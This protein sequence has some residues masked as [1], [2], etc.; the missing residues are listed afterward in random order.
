LLYLLVAGR[1]KLFNDA[2]T[3]WHI[4]VGRATLHSGFITEDN[5]SFTRSGEPW[6]ANQWLAECALAIADALG[7][8]DGV[9]VLTVTVLTA[10][11]LALAHRWLTQGFDPLLTLAVVAFLLSASAYT[12]NARPHIVSIGLLGWTFAKLRDV[13]D[14]RTQISQ[15]LWLIPVFILWSN[16]HGGVLG[17]L[18]TIILAATGW[19]LLWLLGKASPITSAHDTRITWL[20]IVA[21][22]FALFVT[23]YGIGSLRAWLTIMSMS[24]PDL[25]IEHAPLLPR[26]PQGMLVILLALV[27]VAIF[28]ATPRAWL[29]P[30]FWLPLVWFLLTCQRIRHAPL[31]A[32]VAGI[33]MADLLPQSRIA[34]WL[35]RRHWL[36]PE[37]L[38]AGRRSALALLLIM[39]VPL[40]GVAI[41][42]KHAGPLPLVRASWV[43]PPARVWPAGLIEPLNSFAEQQPEGTPVFNEPILGGFLIDRFT[44][45]RVFIDGRCEL[46]GEPF[47]H[48]FVHAWSDPSLI[49]KWQ[50][51]FG[52]RAALIEA[53]SPLRRYFDHNP[54][55]QLV[56][57]AH[58]ARFYRMTD[59][60]P[61]IPTTPP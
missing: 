22:G 15:L 56:G 37:P 55:W 28:A 60:R 5:F 40:L 26:S 6:V 7:G 33:A 32:I 54:Q 46:Y 27:Y 16:L 10:T 47:L 25:I 38:P 50:Q 57:E 43:R 2:D 14:R 59:D 39:S 34:G 9:L 21:C 49:D 45:L 24:L 36:R 61:P 44:T 1:T 12:I 23:P 20:V 4:A 31:F 19:T 3:F 52:F 8:L 41:W 35:T 18:G 17:G 13:E 58:A 51:E 48:D 30:T 42:F 11:Y 53:A 29:R